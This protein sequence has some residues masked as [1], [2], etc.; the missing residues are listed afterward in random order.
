MQT[1]RAPG[2][3]FS[4]QADALL[5][6]PTFVTRDH[7]STP[8][9]RGAHCSRKFRPSTSL[10]LH[11][12]EGLHFNSTFVRE[13]FALPIKEGRIYRWRRRGR[14]KNSTKKREIAGGYARAGSHSP[15][16]PMP[17]GP[18]SCPLAVLKSLS[19]CLF[20]HNPG[21]PKMK[22]KRNAQNK[23]RKKQSSY[24]RFRRAVSSITQTHRKQNYSRHPGFVCVCVRMLVFAFSSHHF[25]FF[26][27]PLAMHE[28]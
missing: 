26:S 24:P 19:S 20:P 7:N 5:I 21:K 14:K 3:I 16:K 12:Q 22:Q 27:W 6:C 8:C 25:S 2:S 13:S 11:F 18:K 17:N 23:G 9:P 28:F 15:S 4:I 1:S 10:Q